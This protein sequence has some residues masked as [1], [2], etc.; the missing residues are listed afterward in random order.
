MS[1]KVVGYSLLAVGIVV[2]LDS[3]LSVYMVFTKRVTPIDLFSFPG[4]SVD[5]PRENTDSTTQSTQKTELISSAML[6]ES[7]N[8][9]AHLMLM[10]FMASN[11]SKIAAIGVSMVRPIVVKLKAKEEVVNYPSSSSG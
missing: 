1:E 9:F 10:G 4:I 11:G 8:L 6:N 7:S 2:I 5:V 3:A